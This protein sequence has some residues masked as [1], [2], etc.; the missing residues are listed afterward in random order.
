M[1]DLLIA[2]CS[3]Y[4]LKQSIELEK[5]RSWL[6]TVSAFAN[7]LGGII[8]FGVDN[9]RKIVGLKDAANALEIIS[10][11]IKN[12]IKPLPEVEIYPFYEE[13]QN[14]I[15][16]KVSK[17]RSGP[18]Y[19]VH[20]RTKEVYIRLG[21]ETIIAPNH[22]LNE[23]VLKGL[24]CTYD[25]L[26]TDNKKRDYSFSYFEAT[27]NERTHTKFK[28][29]D[30]ISMNLS[31][32]NGYLTNTGALL[33][34]QNTIYQS[35][36][37]CTHW[38]GKTKTS[39]DSEAIDDKEING[40]IVQ[41]L[42]SSLEFIKNNMKIKWHKSGIYR[43][44]KPDYDLEAVREALVNALIHRDYTRVGSEVSIDIYLDRLEITSPGGMLSGET[45]KIKNHSSIPS[46]RRNPYLADIFARMKFMERRGS[47]LNKIIDKTND[48]FGNKDSHVEYISLTNYF[49]VI[50]FN[51]NY[52]VDAVN[53]TDDA[54]NDTDDA[55]KDGV[56]AVN[57]TFDAVK[58]TVDAVKVTFDE[59]N[60]VND[61]AKESLDAVNDVDDV[62]KDA[63]DVA[64]DVDNYVVKDTIDEVNNAFDAAD[65]VNDAF[66]V[67]KEAVDAVNDTFDEVKDTVDAVKNVV[68]EVNDANDA[69]K[70]V[71][72]EVKDAADAVNDKVDEVNDVNDEAKESLDAVNDE[73]INIIKRYPGLR[74]PLIYDLIKLNNPNI[75]INIIRNR[76]RRD[77]KDQIIFK[78]NYRT[79]G[80]YI[81]KKHK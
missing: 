19:Y 1:L 66:D 62:D 21:D 43:I 78:G 4:E 73:I 14:L 39:L 49:K 12:R 77:L 22:I 31:N 9:D 44:D 30:Y 42:F 23:L 2:E 35:R 8:I 16:V 54:V 41:Q 17:G 29:T 26:I 63:D 24:N 28:E 71:V 25:S 61:E 64:H 13:E 6:K 55:V 32:K 65:A 10:D 38:N 33:S 56:N 46:E 67:D 58:D 72:D 52:K 68:D 74:A 47:G 40:S 51:S 59:V 70:D 15:V 69:V 11:K 20:D 60:D 5:P 57:D 3:D 53:D 18:Y 75:T 34:D 37:F 45:L 50:I 81:N 79:G 48:L 80:Y 27:Y 76:I 7:T 36:V